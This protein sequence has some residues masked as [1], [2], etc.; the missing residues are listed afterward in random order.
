[1][2]SEQGFGNTRKAKRKARRK[3][4]KTKRTAANKNKY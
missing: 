3:K 2:P 4:R 1:M